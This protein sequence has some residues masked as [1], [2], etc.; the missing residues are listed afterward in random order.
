MRFLSPII[1]LAVCLTISSC[2]TDQIKTNQKAIETVQKQVK[3]NAATL[4]KIDLSGEGT[5]RTLVQITAKL[6]E[7]DA[8]INRLKAQAFEEGTLMADFRLEQEEAVEEFKRGVDTQLD[9]SDRKVREIDS[10]VAEHGAAALS[11][12]MD[13]AKRDVTAQ[14][15]GV[16]QRIGLIEA[17]LPR[18]KEAAAI[19]HLHDDIQTKLTSIE[20]KYGS[21]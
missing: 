10:K 11:A 6:G 13:K 2:S 14:L 19:D 8:S 7:L 21:A 16:D 20:Q 5:A 18:D 9:A 4:G 1:S 12:K 3:V 17:N 15:E